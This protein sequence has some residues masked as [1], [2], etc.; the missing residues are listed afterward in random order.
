MN[1]INRYDRSID[2]IRHTK[3]DLRKIARNKVITYGLGVLVFIAGNLW[4]KCVVALFIIMGFLLWKVIDS[5]DNSVF[6]A[7]SNKKNCR[8]NHL[9]IQKNA[10]K[11]V[12]RINETVIRNQKG[13]IKRNKEQIENVA[14]KLEKNKKILSFGEDEIRLFI[15]LG[16]TTCFAWKTL[17]ITLN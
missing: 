16:G 15:Y 9:L 17:I 5:N 14:R 7:V 8:K 13:I 11:E 10:E 1:P 4:L 6:V 2:A 12:I 3:G